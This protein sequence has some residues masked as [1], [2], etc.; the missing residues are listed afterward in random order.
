MAIERMSKEERETQILEIARNNPGITTKEISAEIGLA[1]NT[2]SKI[3]KE[4]KE[5]G[6]WPAGESEADPVAIPPEQRCFAYIDPGICIALRV[7][8]EH[9]NTPGC[10]FYKTKSGYEADKLKSEERCEK[11]GLLYGE[12]YTHQE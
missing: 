2:V 8:S 7:K 6:K 1:Y 3:A 4:L 10:A 11:R 9:C 12:E 5:T